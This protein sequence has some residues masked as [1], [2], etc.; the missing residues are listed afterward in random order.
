[1]CVCVCRI[2][3]SLTWGVQ[4]KPIVVYW[5][6]YESDAAQNSNVYEVA[7]RAVND[8]FPGE[9]GSE[10]LVQRVVELIL[11]STE[12]EQVA[13]HHPTTASSQ[14]EGEDGGGGGTSTSCLPLTFSAAEFAAD[15]VTKFVV[16]GAKSKTLHKE[17]LVMSSTERLVRKRVEDSAK[18]LQH[19]ANKVGGG[20][21]INVYISLGGVCVECQSVSKAC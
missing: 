10:R 8:H 17:E 15:V 6:Q 16:T 1:M 21:K 13:G 18:L 2:P 14:Q 19:K 5:F 11:A 7:Q 3:L 12:K 9:F 4:T 20:A